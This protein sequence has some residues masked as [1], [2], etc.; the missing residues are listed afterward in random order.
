MQPGV[1]EA[2]GAE[3]EQFHFARQLQHLEE[4]ADQLAEEAGQGSAV[5]REVAKGERVVS[6]AF[7]FKAGKDTACITLDKQAEQYHKVEGG[8][9]ASTIGASERTH[10]KPLNGFENETG[11]VVFWQSIAR[12]CGR[13]GESGS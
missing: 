13:S 2:D 1:V 6:G 10:V 7:D 12:S 4:D 8:A 9:V 3:R 5:G 11:D